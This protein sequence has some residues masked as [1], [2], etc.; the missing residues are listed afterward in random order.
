[1][2]NAPTENDFQ[3]ECNRLVDEIHRFDVLRSDRSISSNGLEARTPFLDKAFVQY[4]LSIPAKMKTFDGKLRLE[5][6]LLRKAFDQ[7]ELLPES[8]LWRRKCAF[9][10]GVSAKDN[11]WHHVIQSFVDSKISDEEYKTKSKA[12][13]HCKPI[14]KESYYYRK[15]FESIFG[16]QEKL[17]PHFGCRNGLKPM[18][19]LQER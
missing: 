10:D 12:Y 15:V 6:Y 17:I 14:L 8:V 1:M 13:V 18:I 11:S 19:H 3:L 4:Y 2:K 16:K 7:S 5:K 9:S